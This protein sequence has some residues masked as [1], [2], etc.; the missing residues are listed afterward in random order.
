MNADSTAAGGLWLS[1]GTD[2]Q[3]DAHAR[4]AC[5]GAFD[6]P[7][8]L[9]NSSALIYHFS[10][11]PKKPFIPIV[12]LA[13]SIGF[14][15]CR[16]RPK[17]LERNKSSI[18]EPPGTAELAKKLRTRFCESVR[19]LIRGTG[20]FRAPGSRAF[21][22][23]RRA[24]GRRTYRPTSSRNCAGAA[25]CRC[26]TFSWRSLGESNPCFRRERATS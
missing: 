26:A 18:G 13:S 10:G 25:T 3:L 12:W 14:S 8:K 17:M 16:F 7:I 15:R 22:Q 2:H 4:S 23:H 21:I 19:V 11:F 5:G 1:Q 6:P 24:F 20:L 9:A